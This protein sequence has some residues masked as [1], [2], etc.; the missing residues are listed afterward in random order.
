MAQ[1][2]WK[3]FLEALAPPRREQQ[4]RRGG[5]AL[6]RMVDGR[7]LP[8][9]EA[10]PMGRGSG[11]LSGNGEVMRA[12]LNAPP[13]SNTS[14]RAT[15]EVDSS[16]EE[17]FQ[18]SNTEPV[19]GSLAQAITA[20]RVPQVAQ[21]TSQPPSPTRTRQPQRTESVE[22][23]QTPGSAESVESANM[24]TANLLEDVKY[25]HNAALSYQDAYEALQEQQVEL[26][27]KF[28]EQAQLV[29]EA[30]DALRANEVESAAQQ[31]ELMSELTTLRDQ[32]EV[33]I[34]HTVGQAVVQYREQLESA[35]TT[36][37]QRDREH[38]QSIHRLQEQVRAL[39]V[40]L[41]AQATLP[42]VASSSSQT[43]LCREVF[44]IVP[45]TVNTR[46]GAAQYESPDQAF[47]FQKQ[48]RFEDN[49]S[50]PELGP[51]MNSGE[52]RP[53]PT[54][55]VIPPRLSDISG[56]AHSTR[57]PHYA[58][59]PYRAPI[60]GSTF[61]VEPAA[62]IINE[63]RQVANIAAEVSAAAA[64]QASKEFRRMREPKITK[65]KGG[66]SA[67]AELMF[68]SWR[69][70]IL[71]NIADRELDNKA[72]IQLIKEQTLDNARRE[73]EFQLDLCGGQ[74]TFQDLLSHL[75]VTFQG[76]DDEANVLAE[77]YS[78]RQFAKESEE[79]F[80][81]ELQ[82]LARKVI[83]KKPD[84]RVNLDNTMKQRYASQLYDRSNASI[85]KALLLQMPNVSF[86]Q[87]RNELARVLGTRQCP[88]KSVS[89][90]SVSV[91]PE[92]TESGEE[93]KPAPKSQHKRDSKIKAQSS[94]IKDLRE[95]LDGAIAE[96]AQIKEW[97]NPNTLQTA[98][99]NALQ[100]SGQ[101]R[102]GGKYAGKRR[103]SKVAAGI[104]GTI[105]P[106]KTCVYCKDM[107][108]EKT[109]CIR[110]QK[111][112]AFVARQREGLN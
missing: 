5:V 11:A 86:T 105:D 87:Y 72:A 91:T 34:Q 103:K 109:N 10:Q 45:G 66:Y 36:Q 78:R 29:Q 104:D 111:H 92:S 8:R 88:S 100:A 12:N 51:V 19:P 26:Q 28:S 108:H 93:E 17:E 99:T 77:F 84:F 42:S 21:T 98:F 46:R 74:I 6:N 59:T 89:T 82:L 43:E 112:N 27:T 79:S 2:L 1:Q 31:Q 107:G 58:S 101:F 30:S 80:A 90:K 18:D 94:Q 15:A 96:N 62:P 25:F 69:S 32:R 40:S 24:H 4:P 44:N 54:L 55:P 75:G 38:Q 7:P 56:I 3:S 68:R 53:T 57:P 76:G 37:Q 65:L 23:V 20:T 60:H 14:A 110:L 48:V 102:S 81:D 85:T 47:S 95:K 50:S 22:S 16:S 63:S 13:P 9:I 61:D 39:E 97:L 33:D 67:D 83:S 49:R 35:Q 70:D 71:A 52:G 64:A 73:V 106:E 41:A